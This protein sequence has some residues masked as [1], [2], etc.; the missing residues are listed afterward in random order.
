MSPYCGLCE[1]TQPKLNMQNQIIKVFKNNFATDFYNLLIL[2]TSNHF[3]QNKPTLWEQLF[4][5]N[6]FYFLWNLIKY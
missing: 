2:M 5:W 3:P 4:L 1:V 6:K